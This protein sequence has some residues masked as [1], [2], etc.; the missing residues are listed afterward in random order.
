MNKK[1]AYISNEKQ[2]QNHSLTFIHQSNFQLTPFYLI[3]PRLTTLETLDKLTCTDYVDFGK[4]SDRFG[5]FSWTK[6]DSKYLDIKLK[7]F[8][9]MT[10]MQNFD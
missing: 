4:S 9:S 5:Q 1:D 8:K 7:V 10:K 6:N 3:H 2:L